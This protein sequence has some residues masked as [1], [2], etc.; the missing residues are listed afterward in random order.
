VFTDGGVCSNLPIHLFDAPLPV[1]PTFALNLRDDLPPGSA[2]EERVVPPRRGR[3]YQGDRHE[4]SSEPTLGAVASF[5]GAIVNTMQNWRDMLQ[6]SAPGARERVFTIRHTGD[7]GG[8]NLDMKSEVITKISESG[9]RVAA[10]ITDGFLPPDGTKPADSDWEYHRWVRLRLLVPALREFLGDAAIAMR[11]P[12]AG[13]SFQGL[14]GTPPPM[15]RSHELNQTSRAAAWTFLDELDR[16][17][18]NLESAKPKPDLERT[19]PRPVG[20]LRVRPTF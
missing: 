9:A 20:E 16:A 17:S 10:A 15:G 7:E 18:A 8:L 3:S 5:F 1:W 2:D 14:L 12:V 13:P 19:E 4:L 6:R 11:T